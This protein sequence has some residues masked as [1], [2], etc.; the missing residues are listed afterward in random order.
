MCQDRGGQALSGLMVCQSSNLYLVVR[1]FEVGCWIAGLGLSRVMFCFV[2][3]IP[4]NL[5]RVV[6][7]VRVVAL[8]QQHRALLLL[9]SY[10][11]VRLP[12]Q[13]Y[14]AVRRRCEHVFFVGLQ[15]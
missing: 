6:G 1:C 15:R 2:C 9:F 7:D 5:H 13:A 3:A 14:R 11:A 8:Q 12:A 10:H 4:R